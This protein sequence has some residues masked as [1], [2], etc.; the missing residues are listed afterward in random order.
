MP[1]GNVLEV[2]ADNPQGLALHKQPVL[3]SFTV[4]NVIPFMVP[5]I[6]LPKHSAVQ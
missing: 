5:V 2:V 6:V 1:Q 4:G 3:G